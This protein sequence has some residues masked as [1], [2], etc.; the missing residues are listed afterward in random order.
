MSYIDIGFD[1][2]IINQIINLISEDPT[3]ESK[4][5]K[6]IARNTNDQVTEAKF[7]DWLLTV[8]VNK[9]IK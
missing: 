1:K 8:D 4:F 9:L 5:A 3:L 2:E 6:D 7:S